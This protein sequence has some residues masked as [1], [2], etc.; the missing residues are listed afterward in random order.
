MALESSHCLMNNSMDHNSINIIAHHLTVS[1]DAVGKRK[2]K[3][4]RKKLA[5][6]TMYRKTI[7]MKNKFLKVYSTSADL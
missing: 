1:L 6:F 4:L 7:N 5:L 3:K 2:E